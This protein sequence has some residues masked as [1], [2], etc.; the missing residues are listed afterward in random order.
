M[1]LLVCRLQPVHVFLDAGERQ[2][3]VA[4]RLRVLVD[5]DHIS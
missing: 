1:L 3:L 4:R 5:N 2:N